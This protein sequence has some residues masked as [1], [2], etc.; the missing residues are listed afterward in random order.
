[1]QEKIIRNIALFCSVAGLILLFYISG[2]I[3]ATPV[4][5]GE[6]SIDDVGIGV[7]V[8]GEIIEKRVSNNH[9][10][11]KLEDETGSIRLVVF[12]ST[13]LKLRDSGVDVYGF[14]IGERI[15]ST[16]VVDEYP[17]G[18]GGLELVYRRGS[19]AGYD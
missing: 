14:S 5:I 19:I 13:A 7:K 9:V 10:F 1:M 4:R 11:M 6:I 16:G 18:S 17:K 15:C 12:N 3:E 8:C 2:Q